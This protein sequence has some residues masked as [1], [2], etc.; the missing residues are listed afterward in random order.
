MLPE[1]GSDEDFR[2]AVMAHLPLWEL[3]DRLQKD[4][5]VVHHFNYRPTGHVLLEVTWHLIHEVWGQQM[6]ANA[7]R[8]LIMKTVNTQGYVFVNWELKAPRKQLW[9]ETML[10]EAKE[11]KIFLKPGMLV[12]PTQKQEIAVIKR[13]LISNPCN[14]IPLLEHST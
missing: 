8:D 5:V 13:G 12:K 14:E 9:L 11:A 2:D 3:M 4:G 7:V 1:T 6:N 10:T